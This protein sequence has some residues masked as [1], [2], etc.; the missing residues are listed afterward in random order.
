MLKFVSIFLLIMT[1]TGSLA[2]KYIK[3]MLGVNF[4]HR[5]LTSSHQELK[6]SL[7]ASDKIKPFL[8]GGIH[9]L[10]E[11]KPGREFYL[12]LNFN[13]NGFVRER[14]KLKFNDT[15]YP[16]LGRILDLSEAAQKNAYYTYRFK[17]LELPIGYN[18]QITPRRNMNLFTGWFNIGIAPQLLLKQNTTIVLQGFTM[19]GK[20]R[21]NFSN[22]GY[23]A[24]NF[25]LAFQTGGR[26]DINIKNK[27][28]VTT[29]ALFKIQLLENANNA[30]QK[31]RTYYFNFNLGLRYEIGDF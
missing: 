7:D 3:P 16:E 18:F 8:T 15:V 13:E 5:I 10:F 27:Y 28:W 24:N 21:F 14:Y 22:T 11:K 12:G 26:F 1:Y 19:K 31:L 9:F 4:S 29:D 30:S 17:Y 2:Q 20:N 25:N 6:D 23:A